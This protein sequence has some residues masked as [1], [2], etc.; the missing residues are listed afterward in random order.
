[1]DQTEGVNDLDRASGWW[2]WSHG[3]EVH[4]EDQASTLM[5]T[6]CGVPLSQ[7]EPLKQ[8]EPP[9]TICNSCLVALVL[10]VFDFR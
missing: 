4:G 7:C 2:L 3:G 9:S 1:M 5:T 6:S 8:A 10:D